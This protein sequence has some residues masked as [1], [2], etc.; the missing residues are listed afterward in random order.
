[1]LKPLQHLVVY[2]VSQGRLINIVAFTSQPSK[3]STI[4]P[5]AAVTDVSKEELMST[6]FGWEEEVQALLKVCEMSH[7]RN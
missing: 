1:M 3:E 6:Y 5:G 2:P 4:F 7:A